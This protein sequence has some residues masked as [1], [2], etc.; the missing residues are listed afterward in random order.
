MACSCILASGFLPPLLVFSFNFCAITTRAVLLLQCA[1]SAA[2]S[3]VVD[4]F[5]WNSSIGYCTWLTHTL[6]VIKTEKIDFV[7]QIKTTHK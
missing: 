4:Y 5:L 1:D 6:L 2:C 3:V 7:K